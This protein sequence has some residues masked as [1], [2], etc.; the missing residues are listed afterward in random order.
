MKFEHDGSYLGYIPVTSHNSNC[1][2]GDSSA[3][4]RL[5]Q[6]SETVD[7][8]DAVFILLPKN[9]GESLKDC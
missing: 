7:S 8:N 6:K 4:S 5:G 2:P 3:Q 9:G 1:S